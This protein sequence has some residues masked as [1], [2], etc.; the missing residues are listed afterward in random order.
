MISSVSIPH[1]QAKNRK[2]MQKGE[3]AKS[4]FQFLIGRLKTG[5][6]SH[7]VVPLL[8]FQFLIGRLKTVLKAR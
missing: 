8:M 1:R 2:W 3:T 6:D 4:G 7:P 5:S